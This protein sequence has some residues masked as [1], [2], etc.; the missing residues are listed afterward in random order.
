MKVRINNNRS[1]LIDVKQISD[2]QLVKIILRNY[3]RKISNF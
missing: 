1:K 2:M 3:Y